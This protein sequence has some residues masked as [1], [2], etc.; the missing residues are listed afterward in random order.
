[1]AFYR[2][3]AYAGLDKNIFEVKTLDRLI[4]VLEDLSKLSVGFLE[5]LGGL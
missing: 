4:S 3:T 2:F 5:A 1:M